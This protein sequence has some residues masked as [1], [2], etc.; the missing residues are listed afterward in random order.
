[1]G[2]LLSTRRALLG[3]VETY[4]DKIM[5]TSPTAYWPQNAAST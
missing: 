5:R 2:L 3:A 4:N 1:M